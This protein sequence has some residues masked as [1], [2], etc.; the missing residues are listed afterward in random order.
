MCSA[1]CAGTTQCHGPAA[2]ASC[3]WGVAAVPGSCRAG[4]L[5]L[6][7]SS[8]PD[9]KPGADL[10]SVRRVLHAAFLINPQMKS[11]PVGR[12]KFGRV[13]IAIRLSIAKPSC[14]NQ[15]LHALALT[16]TVSLA[17]PSTTSTPRLAPG[18]TSV[19]RW[20]RRHT[21]N[22]SVTSALTAQPAPAL[23]SPAKGAATQLKPA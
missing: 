6:Q 3:S 9:C 16:L 7:Q 23:A 18:L 14:R 20:W 17:A 2:S 15:N 12:A 1:C 11:S 22:A 4:A 10:A 19:A 13:R 5:R 8:D 21:E